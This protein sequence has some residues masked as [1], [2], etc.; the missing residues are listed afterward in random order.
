MPAVDP[1]HPNAASPSAAN[2]GAAN[3]SSAG[4]ARDTPA[5]RKAV[6]AAAEIRRAL[7]RIAHEILER[8]DGAAGVVLLGIPTRGV[9]LAHRLAQ[10][11][12][13][14]EDG[15][16]ADRVTP[17][18][19]LDIT[20]YRDD[21]RLRPARTLGHTD[22]QQMQMDNICGVDSAVIIG[23]P[24]LFDCGTIYW[25]KGVDAVNYVSTAALEETLLCR[26]RTA[27]FADLMTNVPELGDYR[28]SP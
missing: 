25:K 4:P 11:L 15:G 9:P 27:Q 22:L 24:A 2:S 7:T 3:S 14:A 28:H 23:L 16:G 17:A 19:S 12:S 18:G 13:T 26:D 21:L 5:A 8:T 6:L 1:A 10:R 20:M